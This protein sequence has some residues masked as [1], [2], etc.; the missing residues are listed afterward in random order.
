MS[1]LVKI[2]ISKDKKNIFVSESSKFLS[3]CPYF[4]N[5]HCKSL[6][7]NLNGPC[8]LCFKNGVYDI[9][10]SKKLN[11]FFTTKER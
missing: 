10:N 5:N 7:W 6:N 3:K 1:N 8:G 4:L 9:N 2:G 11:D